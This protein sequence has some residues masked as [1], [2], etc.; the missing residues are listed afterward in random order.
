MEPRRRQQI[1][2]LILCVM[3]GLFA[4]LSKGRPY[5]A[6]DD[7]RARSALVALYDNQRLLH[8]VGVSNLHL[9]SDGF[10]GRYC[11]ATVD[12]EKGLR[13][14]VSYEYVFSGKGNQTLSMW[15]DYNGG[16]RGPVFW[17]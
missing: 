11:V 17:R 9:R 3:F 4:L 8:A 14:D 2:L 5:P 7:A 13:D 10:K 16:M 6:C 15:I 1:I 12:W